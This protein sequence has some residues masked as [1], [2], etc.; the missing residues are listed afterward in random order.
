METPG[1]A[2]AP[3]VDTRG[4]GTTSLS[5]RRSVAPLTILIMS[6][7][8]APMCWVVSSE[9]SFLCSGSHTSLAFGPS[10]VI[11]GHT[12]HKWYSWRA[13]ARTA[14]S[15][16]GRRP[17]AWTVVHGAAVHPRVPCTPALEP[18]REPAV[19]MAEGPAGVSADA[20]PWSLKWPTARKYPRAPRNSGPTATVAPRSVI[21]TVQI[22]L[23]HGDRPAIDGFSSAWCVR[24][25]G[26]RRRTCACRARWWS[27][28]R[29]TPRAQRLLCYC[30]RENGQPHVP[31]VAR[32]RSKWVSPSWPCAPRLRSAR[33]LVER[34]RATLPRR[35]GGVRRAAPNSSKISRDPV[36]LFLQFF[37]T[38]YRIYSSDRLNSRLTFA[39]S[40]RSY[41]IYDYVAQY[42]VLFH[43]LWMIKMHT[44]SY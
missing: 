12:I 44:V 22:L 24:I 11:P 38:V 39:L 14:A 16:A 23:C 31:V 8:S 6:F 20:P 41:I 21:F 35:V 1:D 28:V 9:S 34:G 10:R 40:E 15:G 43:Q 17:D 27:S 29:V 25:R 36:P 26:E 13:T 30:A 33:R 18:Q 4:R 37:S 42:K 2:R 3:P 5:S 19:A 32:A 7:W